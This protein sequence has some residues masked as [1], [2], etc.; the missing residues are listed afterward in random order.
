MATF[1]VVSWTA[2][3][4]LGF[5]TTAIVYRTVGP[6]SYGIWATIAALRLFT[7]VFDFWADAQHRS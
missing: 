4:I 5:S 6:A 3:A 7:S 1:N 2:L